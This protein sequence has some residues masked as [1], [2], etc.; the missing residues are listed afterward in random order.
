MLLRAQRFDRHKITKYKEG[1]IGNMPIDNLQSYITH[2]DRFI[3]RKKGTKFYLKEMEL[4]TQTAR[5]DLTDKNYLILLKHCDNDMYLIAS[6]AL[7]RDD[8]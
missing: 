2:F 5:R 3:K 6:K 7:E 1:G 4:F 8:V